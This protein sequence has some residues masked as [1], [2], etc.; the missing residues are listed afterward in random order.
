MEEE[1]RVKTTMYCWD[2]QLKKKAVI[3][4]FRIIIWVFTCKLNSDVISVINNSHV[5]K[6][7]TSFCLDS[8]Q[9][10]K[11]LCTRFSFGQLLTES[12]VKMKCFT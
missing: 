3:K 2:I 8:T 6:K 5:K 10:P 12:E 9:F 4:S 1:R 11:D 7:I